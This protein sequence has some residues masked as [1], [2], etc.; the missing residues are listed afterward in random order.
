[1]I[2]IK[3]STICLVMLSSM[4]M[5][6]SF[7]SEMPGYKYEKEC[8]DIHDY[9]P[10]ESDYG[11]CHNGIVSV[12]GRDQINRIFNEVLPA[13]AKKIESVKYY[14]PET[15]LNG[16]DVFSEIAYVDRLIR[17]YKE[18]EAQKYALAYSRQISLGRGD[19]YAD[20]YA[21]NII[22]GNDIRISEL[23]ADR[24]VKLYRS[25]KKLGLIHLIAKFYA[26][27]VADGLDEQDIL[28]KSK[29]YQEQYMEN[30]SA[31]QDP[32]IA[33]LGIVFDK[34]EYNNELLQIGIVEL[35]KKFYSSPRIYRF[36]CSDEKYIY[37][38][39]YD[40]LHKNYSKMGMTEVEAIEYAEKLSYSFIIN[41]RI[42]MELE[43]KLI[44]ICTLS[45]MSPDESK[46]YA[47]EFL[48]KVSEGERIPYADAYARSLLE[49]DKEGEEK[50]AY[51]DKFAKTYTT[52]MGFI[53]DRHK[54]DDYVR[55]YIEKS[56]PDEDA[57]VPHLYAKWI[58][59]G[60][61]R[62]SANSL[63]EI[64]KYRRSIGMSNAGAEIYAKLEVLGYSSE[65]IAIGVELVENNRN[66]DYSIRYC[67]S[68]AEGISQK[69]D[70]ETASIYADIITRTG[71]QGKYALVFSKE[72]IKA[73]TEAENDD[74]KDPNFAYAYADARA[75]GRDVD[76][77]IKYAKI[78]LKFIR[79][80][81]IKKR[82]SICAEWIADGG[83][84]SCAIKYMERYMFFIND[85]LL[86]DERAK[87][88][89]REEFKD[90]IK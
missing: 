20:A 74:D 70:P 49:N 21:F 41:M 56:D 52:R 79:K 18:E 28:E 6:S 62:E 59:E 31:G 68:Y 64:Y 85:C 33:R 44:D 5:G 50:Y 23:K 58:I 76:Y 45:G 86:S 63:V 77:S 51:A 22:N 35:L 54:L 42:G 39:L 81:P 3:K 65:I 9:E 90:F 84:R 10:E 32:Y 61:D 13:Y 15:T 34:V 80:I 46:L 88:R 16:N 24:Y 40:K 14:R 27:S 78:Y 53:Y 67:I 26:R 73:L 37:E 83:N 82:A 66:I 2:F 75:N 60:H 12:A 25:A 30:L 4:I 71:K 29:K 89:A 57:N 72:Y 38:A 36:I 19:L 1:M 43:K 8:K 47:K 55:A 48:K 87:L 17:G 69:L 11:I 7:A